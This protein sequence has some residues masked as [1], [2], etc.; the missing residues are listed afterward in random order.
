MGT[1]YT[2]SSSFEV[3][4]AAANSAAAFACFVTWDR[5]PWLGLPRPVFLGTGAVVAGTAGV[6][7]ADAG[8]DCT[9]DST[10]TGLLPT[11]G[12]GCTS[13]TAAGAVDDPASV[14]KTAA[15]PD[16]I[17][18]GVEHTSI[19]APTISMRACILRKTIASGVSRIL[20]LL[21]NAT[22]VRSVVARASASR[23]SELSLSIRDARMCSVISF[24]AALEPRGRDWKA[25]DASG[26]FSPSSVSLRMARPP[27]DA[28]EEP[29]PPSPPSAAAAPAAP[30][31]LSTWRNTRQHSTHGQ[32]VCFVFRFVVFSFAMSDARSF[33]IAS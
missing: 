16:K 10:A 14:T 22:A 8:G 27:E 5:A 25:L 9:F 28:L 29:A 2:L 20:A 7:S 6:L 12:G 33:H 26:P 31:N 13:D 32:V 15:I 3:V 30:L 4:D 21:K 24:L 11:G 1:Q 19:R 23:A 17:A 18:G